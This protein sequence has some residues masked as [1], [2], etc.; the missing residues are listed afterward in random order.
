MEKPNVSSILATLKV[1]TKQK[2][3]QK[4]ILMH[5]ELLKTG[6]IENNIYVGTQFITF[7]ARCGELVK[8]KNVFDLILVR[9]I[10]SWTA[11]MGGYNQHELYEESIHCFEQMQQEGISPDAFA[12]VCI[13]KTYANIGASEKGKEIHARI[14]VGEGLIEKNVLVGTSLV[15]MYAKCGKLAKAQEMLDEILIRDVISWNVIITGYVQHGYGEEALMCYE[16]MQWEGLSPNVVTF[17]CILKACGLIRAL[18]NGKHVHSRINGDGLLEQSILLGNALVDMYAKCGMYAKARKAHKELPVRNVVSWNALIS[19]YTQQGQCHEALNC[20]EEMQGEG[21]TPHS[22]TYTCILNA[23]GKVRAIE[24]GKQIHNEIVSRGLVDKDTVLGNALVDMYAKC[25]EVEKAQAVFDELQVKDVVSWTAL[26]TGYAQLG[27]D[28]MVI[29][30]FKGM[31]EGGI[32]PNLVTFSVVLNAYSHS[33]DLELSQIF[34]K[35][36]V[37]N[38]Y[39]LPTFEHYTCLV[40]L[41]AR[42]GHFDKALVVIKEMPMFDYLPIWTSVLGACQ[43]W[44]NVDVGKWVFEQLLQLD[45][46]YAAAYIGMEN[47]YASS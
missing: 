18:D 23:C 7:Y 43:K 33:G 13:L 26:M 14:A 35:F 41:F 34:F 46:N 9:N 10:V 4:G 17:V 1:V 15:D 12:Y 6:L 5:D 3:L 28:N 31:T 24:K 29:D 38:Y 22:V 11:L 37:R 16:Q 2:D 39:I 27:K 47:I 44:M 45:V 36:M 8:G 19:G 21:F 32:I 42:A 40:D 20:F 25:G 30:M